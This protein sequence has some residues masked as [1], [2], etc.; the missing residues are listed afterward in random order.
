MTKRL[1]IFGV[2]AIGGSIGGFLTK[3]NVPVTLIDMWPANV[4]AIRSKGLKVTTL[5][6]EFT[7]H[8]KALHLSDVSA[9]R[10]Q[11]DVVFLAVKSYDTVWSVKFIESYLAPG[12]FI[13]SSQNSIND[14]AIAELVGW[15]RVIGC[16]VTF[17]AGMYEPGHVEYTTPTG[18]TAFTVGEPGG[19]ITARLTEL[20]ETMN[21]GRAT[22]T[23]AN[24]WGERWSKLATNSMANALAGIT[25]LKSGELRTND[26]TRRLS[27]RVAAELVQVGTTLGVPIT[28]ITGIE[29]Q[30]FVKALKDGGA[31][32]E[33]E[34]KLVEFAKQIG[35]GRPSLAQDM[36]KGRKVE[37]DYLNGYVVR[38]GKEVG[39]ATPV[40]EAIVRL[41]KRVEAGELKP[42]LSNLS[43]IPQ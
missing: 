32:E 18:R 3:A 30:M 40:N 43:Q 37:V 17:G 7:V 41:C 22:K 38:R 35:V 16:V 20:A 10:Q 1:A 23:T 24:L 39:V 26:Q 8:P 11:W 21:K 42:G 27:I 31:M 13:V 14:E 15:S 4:E 36:M 33:V 5:E 29:P 2:G 9:A 6:D 12:G 19:L 34:G 28:P 25:G